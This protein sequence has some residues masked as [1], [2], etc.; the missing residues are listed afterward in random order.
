VDIFQTL[1][2]CDGHIEDGTFMNILLNL[3]ISI[4]HPNG[5]LCKSGY[6]WVSVSEEVKHVKV[7]RQTDDTPSKK[8]VTP[9]VT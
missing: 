7:D 3:P 6:K 9:D 4:F 1:H 5:D 2:S 8:E